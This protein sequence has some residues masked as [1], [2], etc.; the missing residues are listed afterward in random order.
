MVLQE[1]NKAND[2]YVE[3]QLDV[4]L[5]INA[6]DLTAVRLEEVHSAAKAE[7]L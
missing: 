2:A 3:T 1:T 6:Y 5:N 7:A 4:Y